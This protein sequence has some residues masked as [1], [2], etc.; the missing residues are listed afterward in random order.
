MHPCFQIDQP[1]LSILAYQNTAATEQLGTIGLIPPSIVV[2]LIQ[3]FR[4]LPGGD[5]VSIT[6]DGLPCFVL[7]RCGVGGEDQRI[8]VCETGTDF[9]AHPS[10]LI[11]TDESPGIQIAKPFLQ[12]THAGTT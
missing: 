12:P 11:Q 10:Q 5:V 8:I 9:L 7:F 4:L 3:G 1:N 2:C 6:S